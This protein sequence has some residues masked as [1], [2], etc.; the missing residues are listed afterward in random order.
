MMKETREFNSAPF[1]LDLVVTL[2][3][4]DRMGVVV[5]V[6]VACYDRPLS[7]PSTMVLFQSFLSERQQVPSSLWKRMPHS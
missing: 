7:L 5:L 1:L 6:F 3:D 2:L 4:R